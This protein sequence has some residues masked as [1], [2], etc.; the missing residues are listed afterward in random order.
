MAA[1]MGEEPYLEE[2][3]P[4]DMKGKFI[5]RNVET[6]KAAIIEVDNETDDDGR[7]RVFFKLL[8][9]IGGNN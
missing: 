4:K 6:G 3:D 2:I 7:T 1:D 8:G 5:A 9:G